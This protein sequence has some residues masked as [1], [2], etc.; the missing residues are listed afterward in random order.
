MLASRTSGRRRAVGGA[1]IVAASA[2]AGCRDRHGDRQP[3][4]ATYAAG[5]DCCR[6]RH[7]SLL[8]I[9]AR[10]RSHTLRR[11]GRDLATSRHQGWTDP[12][13]PVA[14]VNANVTVE[15]VSPEPPLTLHVTVV[16]TLMM[17]LL[18][19]VTVVFG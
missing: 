6:R 15:V 3:S 18:G 4:S 1:A 12:T 5:A 7:P 14:L 11:L 17:M 19:H 16:P 10:L 13:S 9:A 2:Q 8:S